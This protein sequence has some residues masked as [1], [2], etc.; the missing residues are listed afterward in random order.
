MAIEPSEIGSILNDNYDD[1]RDLSGLSIDGLINHIQGIV[2]AGD[3]HTVLSS[4]AK[5]K[6]LILADNSNNSKRIVQ[7]KSLSDDC[8]CQNYDHAGGIAALEVEDKWMIAVPV[9]S[10]FNDSQE[11]HKSAIIFYSLQEAQENGGQIELKYKDKFP[12]KN[13]KAYAVGI[14]LKENK[15]VVM[16]VTIDNKGNNI[17]FATS[18][19][20]DQND[21]LNF[22]KLGECWDAKNADKTE[23][24]PKKKWRGYPNSISLINHNGQIYFVG[25]HN[26]KDG[27]GEDWVDIYRTNLEKKIIPEKWLVKV[28]NAHV[29]CDGAEIEIDLDL[30]FNIGKKIAKSFFGP[31]FRWGGSAWI[32]NNNDMKILEVLAV[33]RNFYNNKVK[34]NKF[35]FKIDDSSTK[36]NQL[37][38]DD[39]STKNNQLIRFVDI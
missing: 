35:W 32:K 31:S 10:K 24:K 25:M 16:A 13:A 15:D 21:Q 6:E 11:D 38:I 18:P 17:L 39:S 12:I 3:K 23:W 37:I 9:W 7:V 20:P 36:N 30:P 19:V 14:A 33:E 29:K 22:S 2:Q 26:K 27:M 1:K 8:E 5:G 34:Y 4:S 28:G